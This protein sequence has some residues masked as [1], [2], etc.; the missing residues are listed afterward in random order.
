MAISAYELPAPERQAKLIPGREY[1]F[2]FAW[3]AAKLAVEVNGGEWSRGAHNRSWGQRRDNEK[4]RLVQELGWRLWTFTGSEVRDGTA[5]DALRR[6]FS[7]D[8][9]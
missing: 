8:G 3:P 6:E 2:D 5:I 7:D 9:A 1:A 4:A